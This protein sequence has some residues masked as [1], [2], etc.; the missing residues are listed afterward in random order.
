[1]DRADRDDR[2]VA[3]NFCYD[4]LGP[5]PD[6]GYPNLAKSGLAPDEF[7]IT[8]PLSIPIRLSMYLRRA[9]IDFRTYCVKDAPKGSWYPI[10]LGWHDHRLDYF[11]LIPDDTL[12]AV[13]RKNIRILFYYHEG[14]DPHTIQQITDRLVEKH[15]LPSDCYLFVSANSAATDLDRFV[16]FAEHEHFFQ[17]INRGQRPPLIN[18]EPRPYQFTALNRTHK[19]WRASVM[20]D[21]YRDGLLVNSLWSYNTGCLIGDR[22]EDNP[23]RIH[24]FQDWNRSMHDFLSQ[25]PYICDTADSTSHND[26][27]HINTDLHQQSYCHLVIET[28]FDADGSGGAFLTEKT[29]K[30]LKYGQPFI[31]IGSPGSLAVLRKQGYRVFDHVLDNSYD[32]IKDN[33]DRWLAIKKLI[34]NLHSTDMKR[35]FESC[36]GDL[37]HNQRLFRDRRKND[38]LSLAEHLDSI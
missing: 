12:D 15:D 6:L 33:T 10:A 37:E 11:S 31:I 18:H 36:R 35:W 38:L 29:Y 27:R 24:E 9:N 30:C 22:E 17:Y 19:W 34:S 32:L 23:I 28:H 2:S 13:R 8:W 26:H 5:N 25:G 21:L 1:M 16:Y 20:S 14:D 3:I 7:D 4:D